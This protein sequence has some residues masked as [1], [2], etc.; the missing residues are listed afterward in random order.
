MSRGVRSTEE[1]ENCLWG[2]SSSVHRLLTL[3]CRCSRSISLSSCR[4]WRGGAGKEKGKRG[5]RGDGKKKCVRRRIERFVER[6]RDG[7]ED[8]GVLSREA[9]EE[10]LEGKLKGV[11]GG[12]GGGKEGKEEKEVKEQGRVKRRSK[13]MRRPER[14]RKKK[15]CAAWTKFEK[16]ERTTISCIYIQH[17]HPSDQ[18]KSTGSSESRGVAVDGADD[19]TMDEGTMPCVWPNKKSWSKKEK[20][21]WI[22]VGELVLANGMAVKAWRWHGGPFTT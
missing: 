6:R 9:E 11:E 7:A 5:G 8:R 21:K 14:D 13:K 16:R 3:R 17:Y 12:N 2:L 18:Y 15:V 1:V 4:F 19:Q 10:K 20:I 22:V